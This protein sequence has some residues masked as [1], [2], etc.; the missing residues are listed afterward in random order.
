MLTKILKKRSVMWSDM[1]SKL[2]EG[3]RIDRSTTDHIFTLYDLIQK[4]F[5]KSKGIFYCTC[6]DFSRA[7]DSIPHT[8]LWYRLVENGI[9]GKLLHVLQ[10]I[11]YQ[12]K[13]CIKIPQGLSDYF[14]CEIGIR[15]GCMIRPFCLF[16]NELVKLCNIAGCN[17][18]FLNETYPNAQMLMF[19]D[20]IAIFNDSIWETTTTIKCTK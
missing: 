16:I 20:D 11:Y 1:H 10:S 4:Y 3:Y 13:S 8:H 15:Q 6:V 19:T 7:F 18:L 12:L 9:H 5:S 14:R 17:G 2:D